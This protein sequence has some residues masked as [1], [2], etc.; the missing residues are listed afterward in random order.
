MNS[1][2]PA[3][4]EWYPKLSMDAKHTLHDDIVVIPDGV[5]EEI[6]EIVGFAVPEGA[7]LSEADRDFIRTQG[8]PVD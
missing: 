7:T 4:H 6:G 2:L 8:E 1:E 3:I 5:R